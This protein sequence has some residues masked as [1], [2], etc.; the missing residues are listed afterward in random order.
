MAA[1]GAGTLAVLMS[2][3]SGSI[4][5]L[6]AVLGLGV[7]LAIAAVWSTLI[8]RSAA[9][10]AKAA[11]LERAEVVRSPLGLV[12]LVRGAV[13]GRAVR[14][15]QGRVTVEVAGPS[16]LDAR[17]ASLDAIARG[18]RPAGHPYA[19]ERGRAA[20]AQLVALGAQ[21]VVVTDRD[22]TVHGGDDVV[23]LARAAAALALAPALVRFAPGPP[24][25]SGCP[26][27]HGVLES[28]RVAPAVR[29][30]GCDTRQHA[31]CWREHGGCAVF[32]CRRAPV[33]DDDGARR[34]AA[35]REA[36]I[37]D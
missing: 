17:A 3:A 25:G 2:L 19:S 35:A 32:R 26:Y 31:E 20:A 28:V 37:S 10:S 22:V 8:A 24:V 5:L 36:G 15:A 16:A 9:L 1:L 30:D 34:E 12:Y 33:T 14:V 27:C 29:C 11:A 18:D 4:V 21:R 7:P 6:A 23:A 13:D